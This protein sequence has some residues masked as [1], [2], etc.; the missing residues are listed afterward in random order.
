MFVSNNNDMEVFVYWI[1][2]IKSPQ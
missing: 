2:V 1:N